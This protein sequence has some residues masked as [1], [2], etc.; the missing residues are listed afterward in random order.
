M[1]TRKSHVNNKLAYKKREASSEGYRKH[2]PFEWRRLWLCGFSCFL[3]VGWQSSNLKIF[4]VHVIERNI[5][6]KPDRQLVH[7]C[8][9]KHMQGYL[10]QARISATAPFKIFSVDAIES[11]GSHSK[12]SPTHI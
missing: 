12:I 2:G 10:Q 5:C 11:K 3:D 7:V 4:T 1:V 6:I 8:H 9:S